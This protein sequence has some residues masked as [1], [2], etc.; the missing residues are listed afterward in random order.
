MILESAKESE[1]ISK[2]PQEQG[3]NYENK[4]DHANEEENNSKNKIE[5][6]PDKTFTQRKYYKSIQEKFNKLLKEINRSI[7]YKFDVPYIVEN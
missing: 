5:I 1:H 3:E 4:N 7:R 2:E 6:I